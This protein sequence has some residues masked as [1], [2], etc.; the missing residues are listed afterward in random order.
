MAKRTEQR[1][2]AVV[3]Y[4]VSVQLVAFA[5][6]AGLFAMHGLSADHMLNSSGDWAS[7]TMPVDGSSPTRDDGPITTSIPQQE[8]S[9]QDHPAMKMG[10]CVAALRSQTTVPQP[11]P[12]AT[13]DLPPAL[14][15]SAYLPPLTAAARAPPQPTVTRLCISR[16]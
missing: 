13:A 4:Y 10:G 16:T 15:C 5:A 9:R 12:L 1:R 3:L 2:G 11:C 6:L 8:S 7:M 14:R